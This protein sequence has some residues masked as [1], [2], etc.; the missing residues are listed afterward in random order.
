MARTDGTIIGC[1]RA[2]CSDIYNAADEAT[3][4]GEIRSAVSDALDAASVTAADLRAGAF[5]L[6]GA[7]WPEDIEL[8]ENAVREFGFGQQ[9]LVVN[10]AIGALRAG[11]PDGVGVGVTCGTGIA[12]GALNAEG[13]IWYS[14]HWPVAAGG[15][16]LGWRA[17]RAV[18]AA[19]LGVA[20]D[21]A[22]T[23]GILKYFG[24][25]SVEAVLHRTTAR[26]TNWGAQQQAK[27]AP[28]LL[29]KAALDD[30]VALGIAV[31]AA[32]RH[33]DA[34]LIAASAVG[35]RDRAFRLVL[36]GGVLRHPSGLLEQ[37]ICER[38]AELAPAAEMVHDPPEPVVGAVLLA[39]DL[40]EH[41]SNGSVLDRLLETLPGRELFATS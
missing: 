7:D 37:L 18:Y 23:E 25:E 15:A 40:A 30:D 22:L 17:L 8:L 34:A 38:V 36:N 11:T 39:L 2:G 28:I 12:I 20:R 6:A 26:G 29:D 5:S 21:T 33:A 27:L 4:L 19:H 41:K 32:T 13:K 10:D 9:T 31:Q 35:L 3:A 24:L 16:E 1:G 14:G